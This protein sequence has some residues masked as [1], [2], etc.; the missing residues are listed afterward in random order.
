MHRAAPTRIHAANRAF[1]IVERQRAAPR[2][3]G[4]AVRWPST[5]KTHVERKTG[6]EAPVGTHPHPARPRRRVGSSTTGSVTFVRRT[7]SAPREEGSMPEGVT[8]RGDMSRL[9]DRAKR[10]VA[11]GGSEAV[12]LHRNV[13]EPEH[14]LLGLLC[15]GDERVSRTLEA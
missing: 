1:V 13:A 11:Q 8:R 7:V 14:V 10:A 4:V 3:K 12:R 5:Q 6:L 15:C 2:G 9:S